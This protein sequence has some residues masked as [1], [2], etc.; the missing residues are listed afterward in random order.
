MVRVGMTKAEVGEA[1]GR[2]DVV[3]RPDE[4]LPAWGSTP[5]KRLQREAWVY[6]IFPKSQ[7]RIVLTFADNR[8]QDVE[9]AAN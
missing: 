8:V 4:D 1:V 5:S 2:P 6:F 7:H 3:V 9:F